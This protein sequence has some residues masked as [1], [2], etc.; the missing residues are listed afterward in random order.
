MGS[1]ILDTI[2]RGRMEPAEMEQ[3]ASM[4]ERGL[5]PGQIAARLNRHPGTVNYAMHRLG[6]RK[7]V[8][9]T[10]TYVRN[11]VVVKPFSEA[12][13]QLVTDLRERGLSVCKIAE[14]VTA[15]F[16]HT[17]SPHTINVRLIML[18]SAAE[19]A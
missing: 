9:R 18:A 17:R 4:A 11:G 19:A 12:E 14:Q 2:K 10:T 7:L 3:I 5:G 16:G 15:S 6:Y 1:K 8:R 13:D